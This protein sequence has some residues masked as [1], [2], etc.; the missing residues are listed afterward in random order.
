MFLDML[1]FL[2]SRWG[3]CLQKCNPGRNTFLEH[4]FIHV[5]LSICLQTTMFGCAI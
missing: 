1:L 5:T 2:R 4:S 3:L